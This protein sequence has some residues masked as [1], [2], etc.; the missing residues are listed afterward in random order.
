MHHFR[1]ASLF[2][3][4][5][6]PAFQLATTGGQKR[7]ASVLEGFAAPHT[8]R[9]I[10]T[11][12]TRPLEEGSNLAQ[13][14]AIVAALPDAAR[15][16]PAGRSPKSK[17]IGILSRHRVSARVDPPSFNNGLPSID[18]ALSGTIRSYKPNTPSILD[19]IPKGWAFNIHEDSK[20]EHDSIMMEHSTCTLDLSSDDEDRVK[21]RDDR[22]KENI[23]PSE[24]LNAPV[25]AARSDIMTDGADDARPALATLNPVDYYAPG[26]GADDHFLV[27][28]EGSNQDSESNINQLTTANIGDFLS[29]ANTAAAAV[30]DTPVDIWESESAKAENEVAL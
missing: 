17:R 14:T 7:K 5:R 21:A 20:D 19:Q 28:A 13:A 10:K 11:V 3:K 6:A 25:V 26:V 23:P 30:T 4:A 1:A 16:A 12:R 15:P 2:P 29:A 27:P 8:D 22:G 24:G 18:A 9:R